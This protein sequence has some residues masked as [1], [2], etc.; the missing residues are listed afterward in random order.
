[1]KDLKKHFTVWFQNPRNRM[2]LMAGLVILSMLA[3]YQAQTAVPE[4]VK[5]ENASPDEYI[6]EGYSLVPL[7]IQNSEALQSLIGAFAVVNL[8]TPSMDG[9]TKGT[10]VGKKI[11]LLRSPNNPEQFSALVPSDEA[12]LLLAQP[13]PLMAVVLSRAK[14][15]KSEMINKKPKKSRVQYLPGDAP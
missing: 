2:S 9:I 13:H 11:K 8:Y 4:A 14:N 6:P 10:L 15:E 3:V 5:V 1:M 7:M 12:A